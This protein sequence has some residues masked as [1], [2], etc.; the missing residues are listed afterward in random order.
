MKIGSQ[1]L[2]CVSVA[3]AHCAIGMSFVAAVVVGESEK[4][5]QLNAIKM[6]GEL[7]GVTCWLPRKALVQSASASS[8]KLARWFKPSGFQ[9]HWI[10]RFEQSSVL[11]A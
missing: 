9:S 11:A 1:I 7:S 6:G 2:I 4:S 10:G 5:V 8:F 3:T